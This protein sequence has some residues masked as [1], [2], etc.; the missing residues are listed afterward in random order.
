MATSYQK[1]YNKLLQ[2]GAGTSYPGRI[3]KSATPMARPRGLGSQTP[4][5]EQ[6]IANIPTDIAIYERFMD[7]RERNKDLKARFQKELASRMGTSESKKINTE[8]SVN[9]LL[10][11]QLVDKHESGGS[12]KALLNNQHKNKDSQF[13]GVD[14]TNMTLGEVIKFT[15]GGKGKTSPYLQHNN[16]QYNLDSSPVGRYQ[17]VGDTLVDVQDRGKFDMNRKFDATLQDELFDWYMRDTLQ[18]TGDIDDKID[19]V[20]KRWEGLQGAS[21]EEIKKAI[22]E[23]TIR[24]VTTPPDKSI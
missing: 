11:E 16:S 3:E 18:V 17:F 13:Y 6:L 19:S 8:S 2:Q 10:F 24:G 22:N 4:S 1:A 14:V 20:L 5:T 23:F 21:R 7:T 12:Y 15:G 9:T